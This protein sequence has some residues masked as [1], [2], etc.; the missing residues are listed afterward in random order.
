MVGMPGESGEGSVPT[1]FSPIMECNGSILTTVDLDSSVVFPLVSL[2]WAIF[3]DDQG[4]PRRKSHRNICFSYNCE[5]L[6]R[7]NVSISR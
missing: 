3:Q 5:N 7:T 2:P 6:E 1:P 4:M